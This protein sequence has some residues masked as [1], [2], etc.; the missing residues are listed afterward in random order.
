MRVTRPI[1]RGYGY[2]HPDITVTAGCGRPLPGGAPA[3]T[4]G[5]TFTDAGPAY[6]G[7]DP[8][9]PTTW[10][11]QYNPQPGMI[12]ILNFDGARLQATTPTQLQ[13][14][15]QRRGRKGSR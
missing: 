9:D 13:R 2:R 4:R 12:A 14:G 1:G 7:M 6:K 15:S 8:S 10:P 11:R 3:V 5:M